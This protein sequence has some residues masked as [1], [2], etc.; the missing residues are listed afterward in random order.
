M[1]FGERLISLRK[2]HGYKTRNELASKLGIPSTT[3]RNYETD[4]REPGHTFLKQISELFNVSV[5]YL[6]GLTDE[7]EVLKT[8]RI[9]SSEED[10]LKQY[11]D[12]DPFGQETVSYILDRETERVKAL[13][14]KDKELSSC[15]GRIAKLEKVQISHSATRFIQYYQR[16]ASAGTGQVVFEDMAIDR[17]EIPDKPE[18]KRVSYAIGV[19]GHSME[20]LYSDGDMLLIE[21]TCEIERNEI[22][23]FIVG[24]EAFVKKLGDGKLISLNKGY[25]DIPLTPD[26]KC[27]GRVVDKLVVDPS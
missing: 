25:D 5:D 11:R 19:N 16:T 9:R 3:L 12:L 13:L 15:I 10:M 14:E 6:M 20:P 18:Y 26:S 4:A 7:P 17:I 23:I 24:N 1:T 8:F 22:G 21:P 2:E 27:M